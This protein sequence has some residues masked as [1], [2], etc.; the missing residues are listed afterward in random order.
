LPAF[1]VNHS[2]HAFP[3]WK[4]KQ[5]KIIEA[6]DLF[7]DD[8]G[9]GVML[10][11]LPTGLYDPPFSLEGK[12]VLDIGATNGE[13]AWWFLNKHKAKKV[14]CIECDEKR[15]RFLNKNKEVLKNIEII[16]E[17]LNI[18]HLIELDYDFIKCDIEGYEMILIDYINKGFKLKPCIAEIHT[19]WIRDRFLEKGF[20]IRKVSCD[21]IATICLY[22][23]QNF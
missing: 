6:T 23:M 2:E 9:V 13:A 15:I 12:T 7:L 1:Y 22:M 8:L 18:N 4:Y 14:I 21:N 3:I 19:N 20:T 17:P 11:E 5:A 10:E 16:P